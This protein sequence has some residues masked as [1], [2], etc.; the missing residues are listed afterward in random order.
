MPRIAYAR[1]NP[2]DFSSAS[3]SGFPEPPPW[4]VRSERHGSANRDFYII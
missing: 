2:C 3:L 4:T 1:F